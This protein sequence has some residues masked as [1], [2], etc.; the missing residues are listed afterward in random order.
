[1]RS[2]FVFKNIFRSPV[3]SSL[4]FLL[5]ASITITLCLG[6]SVWLSIDRSLDAANQAFK[7]IGIIE[8]R[9]PDHS[10]HHSIDDEYD[11]SPIISSKYVESFDHRAVVPGFSNRLNTKPL[12]KRSEAFLHIIEFTPIDLSDVSVAQCEI[13][14]IHYSYSNNIEVREGAVIPIK[15]SPV[16]IE[17]SPEV[18]FDTSYLDTG[19]SYL[20]CV[21][22]TIDGTY[23][24]DWLTTQSEL[25]EITGLLGIEESIDTVM[26]INDENSLDSLIWEHFIRKYNSIAH[27]ATVYSTNDLETILIFHQ[28]VALVTQGRSFSQEDYSKGNRVC[29]ISN[30]LAKIN[31]LGLGDTIPLSFSD[32]SVYRMNSILVGDLFQHLDIIGAGS[33]EIVGIYQVVGNMGEGG[34]GIYV[35]TIFIPQKSLSYQPYRTWDNLVSF[36][37]TSG[38]VEAF[39]KEM[40]QYDLPGINFTFYDQGYSKVSGA[41][42]DMKETALLLTG[43]CAAAGLGVILLFSLLFVG[44]QK[45]SIAIMYSLGASRGK[46]LAF[47]LQTVL[48]VAGVSVTIGGV[49]GYALSDRVLA[50]I[51]AR[52]SE[53]IALSAAYSEVY[54]QDIEL[55]FQAITPDKPAAP[56][57]AAGTVLVVTLVLSGIFAAK[58]LR[59]EPMQVL[60]QKEE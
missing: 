10:R 3:K 30:T 59:A 4:F 32:G 49:T 19:K 44:R 36:R 56:L 45:R 46:A 20:A 25:R 47:L 23:L 17:L 48:M 22:K 33:Y 43:I 58:V 13:T 41:L 1:M 11:Y 26:K 40:E 21:I 51:Y 54:G 28:G 38:K 39:L 55:D 24:V 7:T 31:G 2:G 52:G 34:Y 60:A 50:D 53:K 35:D 8:Y 5:L 6:L 37:L 57:V 27:T 42:A 29:L 12:A 9:D 16:P 18:T 14:K 15:V